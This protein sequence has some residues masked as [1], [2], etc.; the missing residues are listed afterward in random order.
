MGYCSRRPHR[1][2]LLSAKNKK[3][4]LQWA[5]DY[6]HRTTGEW[7]NI[8]W[9]D[10]SRFLLCQ[11][12]GRVRIWHEQHVPMTPSYLVST[13]HPGSVGLLMYNLE[14]LCD[15]ITSALTNMPVERLRLVESI[16]HKNSG[17]SGGKAWSDPEPDGCT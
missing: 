11:A 5:H 13:V 16:P 12:D 1:A 10:E 15:A 6:Q 14:Q 3:K 7:K 9:S 17:C 8:A 2:P 4:R